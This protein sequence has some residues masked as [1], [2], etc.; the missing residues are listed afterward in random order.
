MFKTPPQF[1]FKCFVKLS[2]MN[3]K[4]FINKNLKTK[5]KN[6]LFFSFTQLLYLLLYLYSSK[7]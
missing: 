3:I 6:N 2:I 5:L 4:I 1:K 7:S